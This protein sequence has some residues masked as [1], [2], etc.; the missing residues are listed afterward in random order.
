M[1]L[2][3]YMSISGW[4]LFCPFYHTLNRG[5]CWRRSLFHN[6]LC[7]FR[8]VSGSF[9]PLEL[10]FLLTSSRGSEAFLGC[11]NLPP[12]LH[13]YKLNCVVLSVIRTRGV[14]LERCRG[15]ESRLSTFAF[16]FLSLSILSCD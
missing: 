16:L 8:A 5:L 3:R 1:L 11:R 14:A 4:L 13:C 7:L 12:H 6:I 9:I 2:L 15:P 10:Y